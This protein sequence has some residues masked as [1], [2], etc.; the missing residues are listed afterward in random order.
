MGTRRAFWRDRLIE[1]GLILSMGLYYLIGNQN[2]KFPIGTLAQLNPWFALPFLAIFVVLCWSRLS[3]AVALLPLALPYYLAPKDVIHSAEFSPAEIVLWICVGVAALQLLL[4]RQHWSYR[5]SW[6][7]LRQR[8][9]PFFWPVVIFVL[10]A[11]ISLIGASSYRDALRAFRQEILDPLLYVVLILLCLRSRQDLARLLGSLFASGLIIAIMAI[12]QHAMFGQTNTVYG[13]DPSVG[14]LFDY[15]LPIGLA[16]VFSRISWKIRLLVLLLCIPFIYALLH[17]NSR[18]SAIAAFPVVLLFII[19]LAIRNHKVLLV[20]GTIAIVIASAGYGVFH[21]KVNQVLYD[22]VING[23]MDQNHVTTLQ[24]RIHLWQSAEAMIHDQPLFGYG[25]DNWIC[26]Y[27]DPRVVPSADGNFTKDGGLKA[28]QYSWMLSCPPA[29]HYYIVSEE[30]GTT[31][32]M[33]DE[34]GLSHPHNI[35]LHVWVSIGIFGL[36][37]FIAFLILFFWLFAGILRY[38]PGRIVEQSEH[39]RWMAIG[40]TAA[41]LAGLIQGM[42]DSSFLAQDL[43]FCFWL[44]VATLLIIRAQIGLPWRNPFK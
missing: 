9:R 18:G 33:Y 29:S 19:I 44:L 3:F 8:I 26:H 34:P 4:K 15:T 30:N 32:H 41:M 24:R 7:E 36:L 38:L 43:A 16:I 35:F 25:L 23:H 39:W 1:G 42:V 12:I 27:A 14:L 37:A 22:T 5:L 11:L 21:Y 2:I 10:A 40:A 28:P 20:G 6:P 31:T 13:S 17:N